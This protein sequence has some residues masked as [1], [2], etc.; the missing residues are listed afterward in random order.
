MES[1]AHTAAVADTVLLNCPQCDAE[2]AR[3]KV[4]P[5]ALSG[6]APLNLV[7]KNPDFVVLALLIGFP[8][9]SLWLH[10]LAAS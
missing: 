5:L 7:C 2:F 10:R 8:Q 3:Y 6:S 9:P 1:W 4:K